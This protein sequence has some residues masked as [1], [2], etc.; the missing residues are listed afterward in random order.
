MFKALLIAASLFGLTAC[1]SVPEGVEPVTGFDEQRYLGK[2]YEIARLDHSFERG[3]S[4]VSAEYTPREDGGINVINRGY[5]D[6][7]KEWSEAL[8]RAYFVAE[9]DVAHLKVSFFGPFYSSYVVFGLG[10]NYDY[11]FVSG[12]NTDYLWL[13][14]RTPEVSEEVM[15]KFIE[16]AKSRG[17]DTEALIY[18]SHSE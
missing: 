18:P 14:A 3:L 11:A 6:E 7:D 4:S 16:A 12:F 8:G 15:Q 2:W 5:S 10:E 17:F 1:Q 9:R 13:L